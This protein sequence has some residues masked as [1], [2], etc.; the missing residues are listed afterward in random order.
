MA[1][2]YDKINP[3]T[4]KLKRLYN[5]SNINEPD[6]MYLNW[7]YERYKTR[8]FH[9]VSLSGFLLFAT[10]AVVKRFSASPF[11]FYATAIFVSGSFYKFMVMRNNQHIEQIVNPYFEK[12]KVK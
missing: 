4:E 1:T 8:N 12:Y 9:I 2:K 5:C 7:Q 11:K 3:W 10:S 6:L